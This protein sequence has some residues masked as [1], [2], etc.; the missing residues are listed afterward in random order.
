MDVILSYSIVFTQVYFYIDIVIDIKKS[1]SL[2]TFILSNKN[3]N[4]LEYRDN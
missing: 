1:T 3:I 4:I 2:L